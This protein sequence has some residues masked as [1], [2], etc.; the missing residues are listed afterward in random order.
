MIDQIKAARRVVL[1]SNLLVLYLVGT[2]ANRL[3]GRHKRTISYSLDDFVLLQAIVESKERLVTTPNILTETSNLIRQIGEPLKS[4]LTIILGRLCRH[5]DERYIES[6]AAA[7]SG[8][9]Q[10]L[11]LTDSGLVSLRQEGLLLLTDDLAL[12]L[13]AVQLRCSVINFNHIRTLVW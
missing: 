9:F 8:A 10:R 6:S 1:D 7:Q 2:L 13:E 5:A 11:G 3:V 12:F 4:D